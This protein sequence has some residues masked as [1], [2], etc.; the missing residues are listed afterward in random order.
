M[1]MVQSNGFFQYYDTSSQAPL[2]KGM[3][4]HNGYQPFNWTTFTGAGGQFAIFK[5]GGY[6]YNS[7]QARYI[8]VSVNGNSSG[9]SAIFRGV[10]V[11]NTSNAI[12][13]T[14]C[15]VTG[16]ATTPD[17][18]L[19]SYIVDNNDST[20]VNVGS[21]L[22]WVKVD[23]GSTINVRAIN[24]KMYV[25]VTFYN[26]KIEY[27]TDDSTWT[28]IYDANSVNTGNYVEKSCG[29]MIVT[30]DR[31]LYVDPSFTT[32][33]A[34]AARS[35]GVKIGCYWFKNPNYYD[36]TSKCWHN[37]IAD[38][39][40]EAITFKNQIDAQLGGS[41]YGDIY[42][43][44]DWENNLGD[45]YPA[46]TND[47]AY[48]FIEAF[49]NKF[50]EL[51]GRQV[52][53]YTAYYTNELFTS[54]AHQQLVHSSKGALGLKMPLW[55]AANQPSSS[56]GYNITEFG[57]FGKWDMWQYSSDGN[58]LASTY[59]VTGTDIDLNYI[60][61]LDYVI[62]PNAPSSVTVNAGDTQNTISWSASTNTFATGYKIYRDNVLITTIANKATVSYID[63]NLNNGQNYSYKVTTYN[64]WEDS[65][66][67]NA[68]TGTP[69]AASS[70]FPYFTENITDEEISG[71][72]TFN[73]AVTTGST[74]TNGGAITNNGSVTNN[75]AVT[76]NNSITSTGA[77]GIITSDTKLIAKNSVML[78]PNKFG[79]NDGAGS[80]YL[81]LARLK[82]PA[83]YGRI[84][85]QLPLVHTGT[86]FRAG[87]L[88][89]FFYE[90]VLGTLYTTVFAN[91]VNDLGS[92]N[93]TTAQFKYQ[94]WKTAGNTTDFVDIWVELRDYASFAFATTM[95]YSEGQATITMNPDNATT[96]AQVGLQ[97]SIPVA[98]TTATY[99]GLS[100]TAQA[101]VDFVI[102]T[103]TMT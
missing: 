74:V 28:T 5:T 35:A 72:W 23:L 69:V 52:M 92:A 47:S 45:I 3:D 99:D 51:T 63:T 98:G 11:Y 31:N 77:N 70:F 36:A 81:R 20:S 89:A 15:T 60:E 8:K 91:I 78:Y 30:N 86:Y 17:S 90:Q 76:F 33:N 13:S 57:G 2:I 68:V 32:A 29:A 6:T 21:G 50:K 16:S 24:L 102:K 79:F 88:T 75:G 71:H 85:L 56:T 38:A 96:V 46:C 43:V 73:G 94:Q 41:D 22:Q 26:T 9:S 39:E 34:S 48:D 7:H 83:I 95:L 37:T 49:C 65:A 40:S 101:P 27:S 84:A 66:L 103:I 97:A 25:G 42:P 4:V 12:V 19:Y 80:K 82:F 62:R 100:V 1:A 64:A 58:G 59:G 54:S 10:T 14:G 87:T 61:S 44:L 53:L 93:F 18:G 67:S 55:L